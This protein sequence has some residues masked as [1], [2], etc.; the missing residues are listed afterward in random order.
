MK[1]RTALV[2]GVASLL[3]VVMAVLLGI[4]SSVA[5]RHADESLARDLTRSRLTVNEQWRLREAMYRA[6]AQRLAEDSRLRAVVGTG[7]IDAA[8]ALGV[9]SDVSRAIAADAFMLV[10]GAGRLIADT[11]RPQA[12]GESLLSLAVVRDALNHGAASGLLVRDQA[13]FQVQVCAITFGQS[14]AGAVLIGRRVDQRLAETL[15]EQTD[16]PVVI[17]LAE[18]Q[19]AASAH[20]PAELGEELLKRL[21]R[22][23]AD[24][25]EH[26]EISG[27]RYI[28]S[29]VA[30]GKVESGGA[31]RFVLLSSLEQAMEL[32][33]RLAR[34]VSWVA[35]LGLAAS[36]VLAALM[37]RRLA[38]PLDE[39]VHVVGQI[40]RGNLSIRAR[41]PS[42]HETNTL[43]QAMNQMAEELLESRNQREVKQR[44]EQEMEIANTLQTSMLP[45][46]LKAAGLEIAAKMVPASEVGGDYYDVIQADQACWIGIGDVAGHGLPAGILM[47]MIQT[48]VTALVN[49]AP[50]RSPASAVVALNRLLFH[51]V[52]DRLQATEHATFSLFRHHGGGRFSHAGAHES[53][54]VYR[55]ARGELERVQTA[56]TWLALVADV[57]ACTRDSTLTLE[58]GDTMLLFT[59]GITETANSAGDMFELTGLEDALRE[60]GDLS[61]RPVEEILRH[62]F[63][64]VQAWSSLQEDDRTA[65][66]VR[67]LGHNA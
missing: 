40:G 13:V 36:V 4:I 11:A 14:T 62:V 30:V 47:M 45:R 18:R 25:P 12:S 57:T 46:T 28:A 2:I 37:A 10:D 35:G 65:M 5:E 1:F 63:A 54:L 29:A 22:A 24:R 67:Y 52:H 3:T 58:P 44:L 16:T 20:A 50:N 19:V 60:L 51:N 23:S 27:Q 61:A 17:M 49:E 26:L 41:A 21:S 53:F 9:A 15:R 39:L 64:K 6:E 55:R 43:A 33:R 8:T 32:A 66:V 38:R 42:L 56:G 7:D 59:D 48:G 31:L 34:V